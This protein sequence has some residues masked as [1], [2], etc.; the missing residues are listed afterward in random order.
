MSGLLARA[1]A[2]INIAKLLIS[3]GEN[4]NNDE[5]ITDQ[6]AYHVQQ[7]LEKAMKYQ[8]ELL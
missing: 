8:T 2:D 4:P 1:Q 6:A 5:M 7:G 3:P